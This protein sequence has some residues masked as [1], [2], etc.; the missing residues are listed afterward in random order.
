MFEQV[1]Q[2]RRI[3][4]CPVRFEL[5]TIFIIIGISGIS[6]AAAANHRLTNS[7]LLRV[8]KLNT[9]P[10]SRALPC[11]S[12]S[13][14]SGLL[15]FLSSASPQKTTLERALRSS[16][17]QTTLHYSKQQPA[18]APP[19]RLKQPPDPS[20]ASR[21]SELR[22][23]ARWPTATTACGAPPP[24]LCSLRIHL[25]MFS[26]QNFTDNHKDAAATAPPKPSYHEGIRASECN[27][28]S[29]TW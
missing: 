3:V 16:A 14:L 17:A 19:L 11:S 24:R 4:Y 23:R 13:L 27:K 22:L 29:T 28:H 26:V 8:Q 1:R 7:R 15:S 2:R 20:P 6:N 10:Q 12:C 18:H 21:F 25:T 9:P 5:T